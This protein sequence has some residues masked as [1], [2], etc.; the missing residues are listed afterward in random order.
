MNA[1][2]V[3]LLVEDDASLRRS[4][5]KYLERAG[6]IFSGCSTAREALALAERIAAR[7]T[8]GEKHG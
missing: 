5:E 2:V 7:L 4:L 6:C 3:V 8:Q 1:E